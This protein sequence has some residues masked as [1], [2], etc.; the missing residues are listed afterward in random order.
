M[1][2]RGFLGGMAALIGGLA[3]EQAIP[4]GRVWLFPSEI[5][6]NRNVILT[7]DM[8]T[9]EV[10]RILHEKMRFMGTIDRRYDLKFAASDLYLPRREFTARII[11][12]QLYSPPRAAQ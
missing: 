3:L 1:N 9:R 4:F 5:T 8:I 6:V 2:R 7:P 12:P 11:R 10:L